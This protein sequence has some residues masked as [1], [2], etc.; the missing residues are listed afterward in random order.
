MGAA[1]SGLRPAA[2]PSR[3]ESKPLAP[4][5][6]QAIRTYYRVRSGPH[7]CG[8]RP[9]GTR[10]A[11]GECP[12]KAK[13]SERCWKPDISGIGSV[14]RVPPY[15][16]PARRAVWNRDPAGIESPS[17][18]V[19]SFS[20]DFEPARGKRTAKTPRQ[21]LVWHRVRRREAPAP[22]NQTSKW[23]RRNLNLPLAA[24]PRVRHIRADGAVAEWLKAAVC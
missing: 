13:T 11:P 12:T 5:P 7:A 22:L 2:R 1:A 8:C 16:L 6:R 9:G 23:F 3:I 18:G 15:Q 17:G 14:H 10:L 24:G 20:R 21:C 4:N 19:E